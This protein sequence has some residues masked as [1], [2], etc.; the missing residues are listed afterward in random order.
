MIGGL[1]D[2]GPPPKLNVSWFETTQTVE[3][4]LSRR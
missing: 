2:I 4:P 3:K 1:R